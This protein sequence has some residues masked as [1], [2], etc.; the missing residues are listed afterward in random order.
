MAVECV[1]RS[2]YRPN[3]IFMQKSD[4]DRYDRMLAVAEHLANLVRHVLPNV[5]EEDAETLAVFMSE[6]RDSLAVAFKKDPE[7]IKDLIKSKDT[8]GNAMPLKQVS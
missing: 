5:S 7:L 8:Q 3:E 1:Y 4:A 6:Q 2:T